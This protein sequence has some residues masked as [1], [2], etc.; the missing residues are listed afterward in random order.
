MC[1]DFGM[2]VAFDLEAAMNVAPFA[3]Y[4]ATGLHP[5]TV[6]TYSETLPLSLVGL[7]H[8]DRDAG[9]RPWVEVIVT[10]PLHGTSPDG[11]HGSNFTWEERAEDLA[12]FHVVVA[13]DPGIDGQAIPGA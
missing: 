2:T 1:H 11:P 10:G 8:G 7:G 13:N 5:L 9:D 4:G 6:S 12:L 3:L